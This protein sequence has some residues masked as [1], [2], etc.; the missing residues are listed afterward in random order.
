MGSEMC[1]RDRQYGTAD[2]DA[3]SDAN[4]RA[5]RRQPLHAM[6]GPRARSGE[7]HPCAPSSD[8]EPLDGDAGR[9]RTGRGGGIGS[10]ARD[11]EKVPLRVRPL[12]QD[13]ARAGE[14]G[15]LDQDVPAEQASQIV[16]Q[17]EAVEADRNLS[18]IHI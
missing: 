7:V 13:D 14:P 8:G 12:G 15:L 10:A 3:S 4:R 2:M 9:A 1:I 16:S 17:R 6:P 11:I 5:F 18:L